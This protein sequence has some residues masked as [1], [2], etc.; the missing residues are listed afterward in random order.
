MAFLPSIQLWNKNMYNNAKKK[1]F[2]NHKFDNICNCDTTEI[3][4]FPAL[5]HEIKLCIYQKLF[6][7]IVGE[8]KRKNSIRR[9]HSSNDKPCQVIEIIISLFL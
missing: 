7:A 8:R 6:Q 5:W 4:H 2:K 9:N 1:S 3:W